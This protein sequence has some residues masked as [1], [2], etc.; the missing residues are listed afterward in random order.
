MDY[1][2]TITLRGGKTETMLTVQDFEY[3]VDSYMGFEAR[4]FLRGLREESE[5]EIREL[6]EENNNLRNELTY[7]RSK[8]R[9][10]GVSLDE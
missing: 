9:E 8:L 4:W 6:V 7:L 5:A 2:R 10:E 1:P 3:L